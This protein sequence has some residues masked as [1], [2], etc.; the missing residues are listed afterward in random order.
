[1]KGYERK[2]KEIKGIK[3]NERKSICFFRIRDDGSGRSGGTEAGRREIALLED[4]DKEVEE[5]GIEREA[6]EDADPISGGALSGDEDD[7]DAEDHL[8]KL[9]DSDGEIPFGRSSGSL[10]GIVKVHK[11]VDSIVHRTEKVAGSVVV[12]SGKST[13][14]GKKEGDDVVVPVEKD[15]VALA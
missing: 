6:K 3:G 13:V 4:L 9:H 1:M 14:P 15:D 8:G 11:S 10:E 12:L 2:S 5:G 7:D